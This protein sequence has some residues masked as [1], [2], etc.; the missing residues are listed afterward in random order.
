MFPTETLVIWYFTSLSG[1][2][3]WRELFDLFK[4]PFGKDPSLVS[5]LWSTSLGTFRFLC[6][7]SQTFC[8]LPWMH[9]TYGVLGPRSF[10]L[11]MTWKANVCT[12]FAMAWS[13][14]KK[15]KKNHQSIKK[16]LL[17][18]ETPGFKRNLNNGKTIFEKILSWRESVLDTI[19]MILRYLWHGEP[20]RQYAQLYLYKPCVL[21]SLTVWWSIQIRE[22]SVT[23]ELES[24]QTQMTLGQIVVHTTALLNQNKKIVN[25]F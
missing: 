14:Q 24:R 4:V 12:Q 21:Q 8:C 5:T 23:T 13:L 19:L 9:W 20:S 16:H 11:L 25:N 7:L 2:H 1:I 10:S 15:P 22:H 17:S 6:L 18:R 3:S